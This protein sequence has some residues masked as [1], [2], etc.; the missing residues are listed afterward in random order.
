M[1]QKP[2]PVERRS[3]YCVPLIDEPRTK[4]EFRL[5]RAFYNA[6]FVVVIRGSI[7]ESKAFWK[8]RIERKKIGYF[9]KK[10]RLSKLIF[11]QD[12]ISFFQFLEFW[13]SFDVDLLLGCLKVGKIPGRVPNSSISIFMIY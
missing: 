6:T 8:I 2:T 12:T 9:G 7:L 3:H 4:I 5:Y 13:H 11:Y 10:N 1:G